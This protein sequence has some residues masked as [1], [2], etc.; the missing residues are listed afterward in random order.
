[1]NPFQPFGAASGVGGAAAGGAAAGGAASGGL[2]ALNPWLT[3]ASIAAP[4][5]F[6]QKQVGPPAPAFNAAPSQ[7]VGGL[8]GGAP[9]AD[10]GSDFLSTMAPQQTAPVAGQTADVMQ[11]APFGELDPIQESLKQ[12][13]MADIDNGP[14]Q[15]NFLGSFLGGLDKGLQ[16]PA[17]MLGM[18]LLSRMSNQNPAV[19]A[20]GL[21]G[22]G[23][24]NRNK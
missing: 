23:L 17:Q 14:E 20:A 24:F 8:L 15:Q 11:G 7:G 21:L 13:S 6:G 1:M 9:Q 4:M 5:V 10:T 22:M 12:S 18:G 16:S 19:G 3:A 2:S